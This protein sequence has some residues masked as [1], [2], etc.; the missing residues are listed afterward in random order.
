[1]PTDFRVNYKTTITPTETVTLSDGTDTV[2]AINSNI[3]KTLGA[4]IE[5]SYG[6]ASTDIKYKDE[7]ITTTLGVAL[8]NVDILNSTAD[9]F[10]LFIKISS[11]ASSGTPD[12]YI[13]IDDGTNY[14]IK[15]TGAGDFCVIPIDDGL[16]NVRTSN[17]Y[18]RSSG[19]TTVAKI[20]VL[21]GA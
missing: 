3:D 8:S 15:L 10:F 5:K 19:A 7:Y 1:M 20:E 16:G 9:A 12:C 21:V 18:V 13:S 14:T 6:S 2:K 4:G 11:A 17:I